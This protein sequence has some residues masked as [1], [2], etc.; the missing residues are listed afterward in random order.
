Y[1]HV[2]GRLRVRGRTSA[3]VTEA[4]MHTATRFRV[5]AEPILRSTPAGPSPDGRTAL[6]AAH[7]APVEVT[8]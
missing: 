1:E 6:S 7:T 3:E 4:L 5:S 2:G 8:G